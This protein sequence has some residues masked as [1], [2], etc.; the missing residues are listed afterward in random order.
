MTP[1]EIESHIDNTALILRKISDQDVCS[2]LANH[3]LFSPVIA[4]R[5][6]SN[7]T[8]PYDVK[9]HGSALEYTIVPFPKL[10][11][12]AIE[13]LSSARYL[14]VGTQ[15]MKN[16]VREIFAEESEEMNL[17]KKLRI[18]SPGMNPNTFNLATNFIKNQKQFMSSVKIRIQNN[19]L[20]RRKD[21][22]EVVENIDPNKVHTKLIKVA[23]T[24]DQRATDSDLLERWPALRQDEPIILYLGKFLPAKGVG[25]IVLTIPNILS[26]FPKVRFIF[27]GFGTYRE[28]L[29]AMIQTL[30]KGNFQNFTTII[31]AGNFVE[32]NNIKKWFRK[33]SISE[34]ERIT[35]TGAMDHATLKEFLPL[36]SISIIPSKLP[37]AFGMV[38]VEAMAAGVLPLCNYFSGLKDVVDAVRTTEPKLA[39]LMSLD[40]NNFVEELP[41]KISAALTYLYPDGFEDQATR[42]KISK[43]LRQISVEKFS[44]DRIA[45]KLINMND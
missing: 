28:H 12:Y 3:S 42:K 23:E 19:N 18:V 5:A 6:F 40:R 10:K 26:R 14:Y 2:V 44:W 4:K 30:E 38:A 36:A 16:R 7:S 13:G 21:I 35:I 1:E 8:I 39:D 15:Y 27:I 43:T 25:E 37:E 41:D 11:H 32:Q 9:I 29:E 33:L 24:Y 17:E 45:K 34:I 31:R 20:G 22:I